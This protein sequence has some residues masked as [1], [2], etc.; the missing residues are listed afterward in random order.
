MFKFAILMKKGIKH[1]IPLCLMLF[2][3]YGQVFANTLAIASRTTSLVNA[4]NAET[5][6]KLELG[7]H[8]H[9]SIPLKEFYRKK[10]IVVD[11][12]EESFENTFYKKSVNK[13]S[14]ITSCFNQES[15][16]YSLYYFNKT[17]SLNKVFSHYLPSYNSSLYVLF[18]VFRI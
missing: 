7:I 13:I 11:N 4:S 17:L 14:F 3:S 1:I 10:A 15:T 8:S 6:C 16:K 2:F 9:I 18:E 12:E 5:S